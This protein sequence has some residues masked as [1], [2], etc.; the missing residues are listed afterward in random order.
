MEQG[1]LIK[2]EKFIQITYIFY[3]QPILKHEHHDECCRLSIKMFHG[4]SSTPKSLRPL[5][6]YT[7]YIDIC[8]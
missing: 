3:T 2:G 8:T 1:H 5:F 6:P 4:G 7:V